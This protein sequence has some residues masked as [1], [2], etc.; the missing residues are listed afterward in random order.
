[1]NIIQTYKGYD[2]PDICKPMVENIKKLNPNWNYMFFTDYDI[3]QFIKTK[4]PE[5]YDTF[6]KMKYKIQQLDFFRYIVI[7]FYG[8]VYLDL[9]IELTGCLDDIVSNKCAFPCEMKNNSDELLHKQGVHY[10][11][12]N[13]AFYAP[14]KSA[15]IKQ[16]IDNIIVQR[17]TDDVLSSLQINSDFADYA[18]VYYTTGPVLVTQTYIDC[19]NKENEVSLIEPKPFMVSCFGKYGHHKC[20]GT[21]KGAQSDRRPLK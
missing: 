2:I 18:Y 20:F 10:L 7:Y 14:K 21:W 1:M 16:L 12:G 19:E 17:I 11:I 8:G 6:V 5:Y 4:T 13:Y 15:F 3:S 9:D